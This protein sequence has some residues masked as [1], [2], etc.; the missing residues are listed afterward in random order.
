MA[1]TKRVELLFEPEQ[2]AL[3]E[4]LARSRKDSVAALVRNAV[5]QVYLQSTREAKREAFEW[6]TTQ[7]IDFGSW[8]EIK[9]Q[10]DKEYSKNIDDLPEDRNSR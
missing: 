9:D 6:L 10:M 7:N 2:Y 3:L 5:E 4:E 1:L 8:E